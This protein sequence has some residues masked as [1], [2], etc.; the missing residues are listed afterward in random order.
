MGFLTGSTLTSLMLLRPLKAVTA[1]TAVTHGLIV[2]RLAA[3][4]TCLGRT[5]PNPLPK[6]G[7][8]DLSKTLKII[9]EKFNF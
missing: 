6:G 1:L 8:Q 9:N 3:F 4:T 2:F 7:T 5:D